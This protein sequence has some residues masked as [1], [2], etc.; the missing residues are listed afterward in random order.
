[1]KPT[2]NKLAAASFGV[3]LASLY[4]APELCAQVDSDPTTGDISFA[5]PATVPFFGGRGFSNDGIDIVLGGLTSNI[6]YGSPVD[7]TI[8]NDGDYG[9]GV[10]GASSFSLLQPGDVFSGGGVRT[11]SISA[12]ETGIHTI[13]FTDNGHVGYFRVDLGQPGDDIILLGGEVALSAD[14]VLSNGDFTITIPEIADD[15][16]LL[17]DVNL[18]GTVNF[19]DIAPF[20]SRLTMGDFQAEADIDGNGAVNFLDIAPFIGILSGPSPVQVSWSDSTGK[21][22]ERAVAGNEA[23]ER[24]LQ[25]IEQKLNG[26]L[27]A[28]LA[29]SSNATAALTNQPEPASIGLASLASGAAGLRRRREA[30][31]TVA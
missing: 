25:L 10:N 30:A 28:A 20:I 19:L 16:V 26:E 2:T 1:M 13:G 6:G 5:M 7:I 21:P 12:S 9:F 17:G 8:F 3:A 15:A 31:T 23:V 29:Q 18:D 11:L 14:G 24:Q 22:I 27:I 4:S